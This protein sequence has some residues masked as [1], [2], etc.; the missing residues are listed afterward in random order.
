M[1]TCYAMLQVRDCPPGE[2]EAAAAAI[3]G[4]FNDYEGRP[5]L[6][7]D[8]YS[9]QDMPYSAM[10][11]NLLAD[12]LAQAAPGASWYMWDEPEDGT[13][14]LYAYTPERGHFTAPCTHGGDVVLTREEIMTAIK[15]RL[16]SNQ[17]AIELAI[18][19]ATG[20]PWGV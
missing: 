11:L 9:C 15:A 18:N 6:L 14:T 3:G 20:Q 5:L 12:R 19:D 10:R 7:D 1:E 13:G 17:Y 8:T 2:R 4:T 16:G